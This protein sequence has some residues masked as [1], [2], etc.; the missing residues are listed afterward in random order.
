M[1]LRG[2]DSNIKSSREFPGKV[3]QQNRTSGTI[4]LKITVD[5]NDAVEEGN[6]IREHP[7]LIPAVRGES[8]LATG[9][10]LKN[11]SGQ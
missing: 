1:R 9:K 8:T 10:N 11:L 7:F 4:V 3:S 2:Y 5:E 6:P